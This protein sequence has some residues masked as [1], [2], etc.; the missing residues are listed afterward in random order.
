[1]AH[2]LRKSLAL[3]FWIGNYGLS[4]QIASDSSNDKYVGLNTPEVLHIS[5]KIGSTISEIRLLLA[6]GCATK[7]EKNYTGQ[8]AEP[9]TNQTQLNCHGLFVL[10]DYRK[11]EFMFNDGPLG[12]IWVLLSGDTK[13]ISQSM[14]E[15]Y[16]GVIHETKD[17][18]VFKQGNVA[19][20]FQPPEILIAD[21]GMMKRLT[22]V[23]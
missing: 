5:F 3:L 22:G 7:V 6:D 23:K 10:G 9:F 13:L 8:Q 18:R 16:G 20:R 2:F 15:L 11:V 19:L 17:Y 1:V 14:E 4:A 21:E 12:H